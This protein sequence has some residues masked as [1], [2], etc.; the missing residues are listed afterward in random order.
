MSLPEG[1]Q[2][3]PERKRA[4]L[5]KL[6]DEEKLAKRKER[7]IGRTVKG[8]LIRNRQNFSV[9]WNDCQFDNVYISERCVN[10]SL[11]PRPERGI[12]AVVK[13][14][15]KTMGPANA[16]WYLQHPYTD[17]VELVTRYR[18]K[19]RVSSRWLH[20]GMP[21]ALTSPQFSR[22]VSTAASRRA[23]MVRT[24]RGSLELD[25]SNLPPGL[26][27]QYS[28]RGSQLII[29][30]GK[31]WEYKPAV[32]GPQQLP[33]GWEMRPVRSG[34]CCYFVPSPPGSK[35]N[36]R[37]SRARRRKGR[38]GRQPRRKPG[39]KRGS[40]ASTKSKKRSKRP[41]QADKDA[42]IK[43]IKEIEAQEKKRS[44]KK[45]G[46]KSGKKSPPKKTS[47]R[48]AKKPTE[49]P[50]SSKRKR[51]KKASGQKKSRGKKQSQLRRQTKVKG[52]VKRAQA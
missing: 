9:K 25:E 38:Q 2:G 11:G 32:R 29:D 24:A 48:K 27:I 12:V 36:S 40:G 41:S 43:L 22:D 52:G 7:L 18:R 15:I 26:Q 37:R 21:E 39:R 34:G 42:A 33:P 23:S 46:K 28:R 30:R 17:V 3:V 49:K 35:R 16:P 47:G 6:T 5:E 14:E 13:C 4:S 45:S 1:I 50:K 10:L 51:G 31:R 19:R 20:S 8:V 44:K